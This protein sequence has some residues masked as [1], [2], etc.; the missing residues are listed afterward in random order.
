MVEIITQ[1]NPFVGLRPFESSESELFF[2]R[3]EQTKKLL[4]KLHLTNFVAVI[5]SSGAGKSSLVKAGLI[6]ALKAGFLNKGDHWYFASFRPGDNPLYYFAKALKEAFHLPVSVA[7]LEKS[8]RQEGSDEIIES[9]RPHLSNNESSLLILVDQFEELFT[10]FKNVSDQASLIYRFEF[11]KILLELLQCE[12]PVYLVL[13]MRSDFIGKCN[14][15]YGLP[16][17]LSNSQFLVPRLQSKELVRVIENPI[18][19]FGSKIEP[20]LT[21][22]ILNDLKDGEDQLPVL[23]HALS[24]LWNARKTDDL[25]TKEDYQSIGKLSSALSNHANSIY[26]DLVKKQQSLGPVIKEMFKYIIDFDGEKSEGVRQPRKVREIQSVTGADLATIQLIYDAFS[27]E[28]AS[29]LFS[30]SGNRL[31]GDSSVDISHESLMREWDLFRK[32]KEE[33]E[34]DKSILQRLNDFATE[35]KQSKRGVLTGPEL[36]NYGSWSKFLAFKDSANRE[37]ILY[38]ANR[39]SI[40]FDQVND[41]INNSKQKQ[42]VRKLVTWSLV[43]IV[44]LSIAVLFYY[45]QDTKLKEAEYLSET[46]K[47]KLGAESEKRLQA[48]A[49]NLALASESSAQKALYEKDRENQKLQADLTSMKNIITEKDEIIRSFN[50]KSGG[51][52]QLQ[53]LKIQNEQLSREKQNAEKKYAEA[54]LTIDKLKQELAPENSKA[55]PIQ[56]KGAY[57]NPPTYD[58]KIIESEWESVGTENYTTYYNVCF[59]VD[60]PAEELNRITKVRYYFLHD[61]F[62]KGA[63]AGK[64]FEEETSTSNKFEKC[65]I[66]SEPFPLEIVIY[67]NDN[68]TKSINLEWANKAGM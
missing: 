5:G 23:E 44:F 35:Y 47:I 24:Q 22:R 1:I 16:E 39:Y 17:A 10:H 68:E 26:D 32:W 11:V 49:L 62:G 42:R 61:S 41:Y 64:V 56:N 19:L 28:G 7:D 66:L 27:A 45:R 37:K 53:Q 4:N 30:P 40:H 55:T 29:F 57:T 54:V 36:E 38:W 20:G 6:P 14:I 43:S 15:F 3:E 48:E 18:R 13:T 31:H 52:D 60:A 63:A 59:T 8:I 9:V 46:T 58:A 50:S 51:A 67:Y 34:S 12:L 65:K 2:G 33:E 25:I 21:Q